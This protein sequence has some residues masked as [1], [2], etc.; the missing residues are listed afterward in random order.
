MHAVTIILLRLKII[1]IIV[2]HAGC[3]VENSVHGPAAAGALLQ[4]C[5]GVSGPVRVQQMRESRMHVRREFL[6]GVQ[7]HDGPDLLPP[8]FA[9]VIVTIYYL[10]LRAYN[11]HAP[12][13]HTPSAAKYNNY[14][15]T[16]K[17]YFCWVIAKVILKTHI[18]FISRNWKYVSIISALPFLH[19]LHLNTGNV[20]PVQRIKEVDFINWIFPILFHFDRRYNYFQ[21]KLCYNTNYWNW[22]YKI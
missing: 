1:I 13:P 11:W 14:T 7:S 15:Y 6:P 16:C 18:L 22:N 9:W 20:F 3:L 17:N 12:R 2:T 8:V 21:I 5:L 10:L 4:Q 19:L